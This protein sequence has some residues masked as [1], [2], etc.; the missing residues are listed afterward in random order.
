ML[1]NREKNTHAQLML[2]IGMKNPL[3][4]PATLAIKED[5]LKAMLGTDTSSAMRR[6][7]Q[8]KL[9]QRLTKTT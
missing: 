2:L 5:S 9:R 3:V 7:V 4:N 8:V 6:A 1:M